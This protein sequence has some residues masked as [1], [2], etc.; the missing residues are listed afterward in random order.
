MAREVTVIGNYKGGRQWRNLLKNAITIVKPARANMKAVWYTRQG[1]PAEV[2][3]FGEQPPPHAG[4]GQVRVKLHA[5]GVNP[6]DANRRSGR[7]FPLE[8]PLVVPNSDGAGVVDEVGPGVDPALRGRRVWLYNGQR[9]GRVLGTAAEYIALDAGLV[10]ELPD[11]TSFFE[12]A[13]LGI[14]A[15]T[16]H[17]AATLGGELA[18]R[19]VFVSGGAG[20]VGHYA[21]QWAKRLGARVVTTVSSPAKAAHAQAAGA[22][23]VVNYRTEDVA[24]CIRAFTGNAGLHHVVDLDFGA[25][26]AMLVPLMAAMGS[27]AYYATRSNPQPLLPADAVMRRNLSIHGLVLNGAPLAARQ[28]AQ[29][30]IVRWLK[31]GGMQHTVSSVHPLPC[32][33]DAHAAVESGTKRGTVVVDCAVIE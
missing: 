4:D 33:A 18:G 25:N 31:E 27:I 23:L 29:A 11:S 12:G 8:G 14:P 3:Q 7:N 32:T 20:A 24:A 21:I 17:R 5:S 2:L 19:A 6:A 28:R 9:N 22:D 26:V 10:R 13:C 16:A 15:M 1:P 30:D